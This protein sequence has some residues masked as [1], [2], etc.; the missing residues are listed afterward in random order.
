MQIKGEFKNGTITIFNLKTEDGDY[1][2][3]FE[4]DVNISMYNIGFKVKRYV[5]FKS[6]SLISCV[7][8]LEL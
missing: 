5:S 8:L 2:C 4:F 1:K 7:S 3:H 6:C